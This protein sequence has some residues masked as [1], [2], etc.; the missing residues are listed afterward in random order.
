MAVAADVADHAVL[1]VFVGI[2]TPWLTRPP[3]A[4]G[5]L[6]TPAPLGMLA[7]WWATLACW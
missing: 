6:S 4:A 3:A 5:V 2:R 1:S 7:L